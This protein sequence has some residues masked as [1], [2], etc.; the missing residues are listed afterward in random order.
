MQFTK[1]S[2]TVAFLLLLAAP[3]RAADTPAA[4]VYRHLAIYQPH[5]A[6]NDVY[7]YHPAAKPALMYNHDVDIVKFKGRFFAAWNANATPA[8][9]VPGQYNFLSVSDD[10]QQW[11]K[12]VR[13]FYKEGGCENPVETDNQWQPAFVNCRDATLYCA[14]CDYNARRTFVAASE[15]GR[16]WRNHEVPTAPPGL[17]GK[18]VGFPTNH[19][20]VTRKGLLMLPC[21]LPPTGKFRV[22]DT[23]YAAV[24][25]SEDGGRSWHWSQPI[26]ALRW[27]EVGENPKEFGAQRI[28]IWEP[29]LFE[30][31]DGRIGL[32]VRNST[33]QENPEIPEKSYRML[34]Y[35]TSRDQGRTWTKARTVEVDTVCSRNFSV[36]GV[37]GRDGLLMVM[38]DNFVRIPQRISHDRYFLS[39]FLAPVSN[40]DLLLPGPL[41]QPQGGT[42]FY[43][44]GFVADKK[45]YVAYTYPRGIHSAVIE[46]LPDFSRPF[47]LPREGRAGLKI[48]GRTA[49]F[50]Q[51]YSSLGLVLNEALTKA[52]E[53]HLA[54]AFDV[55]RYS[56]QDFP[57][58]TLGG[59]TR[60]G[61]TLRALYDEKTATD[62]LLVRAGSKAVELGPLAMRQWNH[63][64]ATL[65]R[66]SFSLALN[67]G[68]PLSLDV[69]LLHKICFGG[70]YE[71]PEWPMGVWPSSEIRLDL[72]SIAVQ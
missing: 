42:A 32:L 48:D 72:D 10:F 54:F 53:L 47:L 66:N 24:L 55:H 30:Q 39:L 25:R 68:K 45:L 6:T 1:P 35:A 58:L 16:K 57:I 31:A 37:G 36:A 43:P 12:P 15:D 2:T 71:R 69:P 20:L 19:G 8:E 13:L 65:R 46:P 38:N 50:G 3:L 67:G 56:G 26:E 44:N 29:M 14:W 4:E 52:D 33:A 5:V 28:T 41:V 22:G 34:L 63:V 7:F 51:R 9:G 18:V 62:V 64:E 17:E 70:L 27:S 59:R 23:Q 40:P 21:S 49:S 61:A 60:Q 11:S